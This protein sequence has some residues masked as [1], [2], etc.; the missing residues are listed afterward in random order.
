MPDIDHLLRCYGHWPEFF[1]PK[2]E[3]LITD[4][5]SEQVQEMM[6]GKRLP[7]QVV[8][9]FRD[10]AHLCT[11]APAPHGKLSGETATC[12]GSRE[13]TTAVKVNHE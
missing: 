12:V 8:P 5:T 13:S 10:A 6:V 2:W 3:A 11:P 9:G 4:M 1:W 7:G